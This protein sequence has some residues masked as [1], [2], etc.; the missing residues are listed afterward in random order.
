LPVAPVRRELTAPLAGYVRS[1]G[2]SAVGNAAV[3]LG[4]GRRTKEDAVDHAVG[5]VVHAK[6]GRR[7]ETGQPLATVHART[8][9]EADIAVREVLSAYEIQDAPVEA[10]SV[11]L[12]VVS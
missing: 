11:L 7:V 2:A 1:L 5:I 8:D 12:E 4:A 6:R 10:R 9:A 3:H